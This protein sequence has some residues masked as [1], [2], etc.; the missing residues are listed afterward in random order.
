MTETERSM[1]GAG[2]DAHRPWQKGAGLILLTLLCMTLFALN[3]ILCRLAL[4]HHG[5]DPANYT[6][7]RLISGALMLLAL[8][9]WRCR[10]R[11]PAPDWRGQGSWP[12]AVALFIY[13]L[14]FSIAYVNMPTAAGTLV[15]A[16][17]VQTSMLGYGIRA[18]QRLDPGQALGIGLA[19]A[20]LVL[21]LLPGLEAPPLPAA[22]VMFVSGSAWGAYSL[23]GRRSRHA[24]AATTDNFIR[25]VPLALL[26][27]LVAAWRFSLPPE[28]VL[29]AL[30]AGAL[31]SALGYVLWYALVPCYSIAAAAAAQLSVP[32][33]T[34]AGA[35]VFVGEAITLRLV[36]CSAAILGGIFI[37]AL[38][39]QRHAAAGPR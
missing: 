8:H 14:A 29:L 19:M 30:C 34:A 39:G 38:W 26:L 17:A 22:V 33:I 9:H 21:L 15:I 16:V 37:V 24:A 23:C 31:A 32:V 28:G 2:A 35:V 11:Q 13:M 25:C 1:G 20:G 3:S 18:G 36:L 10:K 7:I 12:A 5:M 4:L 6:A 27:L